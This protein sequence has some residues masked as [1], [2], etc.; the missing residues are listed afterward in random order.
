[1][2]I[3][4][5]ELRPRLWF[6]P[7]GETWTS[8][9]GGAG[10]PLDG[11]GEESVRDISAVGAGFVAVGT[12]TVDNEQ[13][14]LAWWSDDGETWEALDTPTLGGPRRQDVLTVA[15]T[16]AGIVAGGYSSDDSGLGQP[17]VWTSADGRTWDPGPAVPLRDERRSS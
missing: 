17:V 16:D 14:G 1:G 7:D 5:G 15:H 8:V 6:S 2:E 10:G 3:V 12:R 11:T 9:D 4:W 13:D